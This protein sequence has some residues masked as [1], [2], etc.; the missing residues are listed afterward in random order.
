MSELKDVAMHPEKMKE[1]EQ[2]SNTKW[3]MEK[4]HHDGFHSQNN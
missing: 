2:N 3:M 4:L 1:Y